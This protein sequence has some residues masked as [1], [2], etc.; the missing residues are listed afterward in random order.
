[1]YP[2]LL[3]AKGTVAR[4]YRVLGIPTYNLLDAAGRVVQRAHELPELSRILEQ[5]ATR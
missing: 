1:M 3:D 5:A 4:S 2:V